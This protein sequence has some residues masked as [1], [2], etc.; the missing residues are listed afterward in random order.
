MKRIRPLQLSFFDLIKLLLHPRGVGFV[1]EI[2][3]AALNQNIIHRLAE[4]G[5]MKAAFF[6]LDVFAILN[7]RHDRRVR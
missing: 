1:E 3:E 5:R 4:R 7:R 6:L 2:V